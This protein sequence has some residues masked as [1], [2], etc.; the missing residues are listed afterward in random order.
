MVAPNPLS[1]VFRAATARPRLIDVWG[2]GGKSTAGK[3]VNFGVRFLHFV[4]GMPYLG[5]GD[6]SPRAPSGLRGT[7][8]APLLVQT[9]LFPPSAPGFGRG[10]FFYVDS[11]YVDSGASSSTGIAFQARRGTKDRSIG[12][13]RADPT[14]SDQPSWNRLDWC[15]RCHEPRIR[16]LPAPMRD[17]VP[18]A[19]PDHRLL[20]L[21][22]S[23]RLST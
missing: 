15:F 21:A 16:V 22:L 14:I 19:V 4:R 17:R 3:S 13:P 8:L 2:S 7:S 20:D 10:Y 1:A 23:S 18:A 12:L 9:A 6:Q 5:H 11:G